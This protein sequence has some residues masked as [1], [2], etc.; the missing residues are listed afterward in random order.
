MHT[1]PPTSAPRASANFSAKVIDKADFGHTGHVSSRVI[2]GAA[3]LGT[4]SQARADELFSVLL[5]LGVNHLD[6]A[7]DYGDSELRIAPWMVRYRD[8]FFLAT[9]T[10]E[11]TGSGAR[12]GL[13][14]SLT[15]LGVDRVDMIQLHDLVEEDEWNLAHG[16][17]GALE[18]LVRAKAEGLVNHIGV[19]GH[20]LRIA[21]MHR[22]SLE[23]YEYDSVLLPYNFA[24]MRD[25]SYRAE[26]EAL[27]RTCAER[28]VAVQTI[29]SGA[30]RRW[31]PGAGPRFSWYE[32]ILDESAVARAV[33]YVL[34]RPQ[35]FVVT[36]SDSRLLRPALSAAATPAPPPT[37]S[38]MQADVENLDISPLFDGAALERI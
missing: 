11:R 26:V 25:D 36:S 19:T 18:A 6:T 28:R 5:E 12:A 35:L 8:D 29:K 38:E 27:L 10:S 23:R 20:G 34:Q 2:F 21:S 3:G 24:L 30:R 15:R 33:R 13:E 4:M 1:G 31:S 16:P 32:P 7:A 37:D 17:G 14:R 22:R 9:K